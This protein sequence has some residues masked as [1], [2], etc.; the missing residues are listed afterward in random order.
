MTGCALVHGAVSIVNA[1]SIG[2]GAALG[3]DLTTT[4]YVDIIDD[5]PEIQ[6]EIDGSPSEDTGLAREAA[7]VVLRRYAEKGSGANV[8]IISDIPIGKGLKS[9][10]AAANAVVLGLSLIHI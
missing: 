8:R 7:K 6:V 5:R 2:K 4:A 10:S 9:S 1:I 3:I